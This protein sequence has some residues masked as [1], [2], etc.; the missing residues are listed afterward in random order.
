MK[1]EGKEHPIDRILHDG[2]TVA[3]GGTTLTAHLT[4]GHTRGCTTWTMKTQ[5]GA[6]AYNVVIGCS[7]RPPATL[8]PDVTAEFNRTFPLVRSLPCDV[9]L[10]D[11]PAQY[12]M[13]EKFAKL[14]KGAANPFIDPAGCKDEADIEEA[15][16][17]AL[18][19]EQR[20]TGR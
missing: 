4:A 8:S 20:Q 10:G 18:Q 15:M 19:D 16:F 12:K 13:Q 3:L 6:K 14:Q 1:P 11:H 9:P 7:L 17:H 5:E 2:D